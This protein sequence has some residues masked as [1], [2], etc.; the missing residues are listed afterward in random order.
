MGKSTWHSEVLLQ[1]SWRGATSVLISN[2]QQHIVVDTGMPH[3]SHLLIS[4]LQ[5]RDLQPADI[6]AVVNT[7]FHIDH[8]LNNNLFPSAA[9]YASQESYD[10]SQSLYSDMVDD[11]SWEKLT[12]KYYPEMYDYDRARHYMANARKLA[13]RWWDMRRL[14]RPEQFK[15]VETNSLPEGI[16]AFITS[17]HV[18]GHVSLLISAE[19]Q[20][21]IIAG[22][23]LLS[24]EQEEQIATMIPH[25]RRQF[26]EDRA[27]ILKTGG[28]ILPGHDA[29]FSANSDSHDAESHDSDPGH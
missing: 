13:L 19:E 26:L 14:G 18:P 4:A 24:R 25:N 9:I 12:L 1:G 3:E 21:T 17:G 23:A 8:V 16:E 2:G 10:W 5:R 20:A 29:A 15:W 11:Q 28:R 6:K 22:D 27:H 7:H